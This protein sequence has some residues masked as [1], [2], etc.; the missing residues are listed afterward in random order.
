M[1]NEI[2]LQTR[3]EFLRRTV[4]GSS[5]TK[6]AIAAAGIGLI[7]LLVLGILAEAPVIGA[8]MPTSLGTIALD[9]MLGRDPGFVVGPILFNVVLVPILFGI[10]WLTF[11]RQEL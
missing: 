10:T 5:L 2:T 1:K 7:A 6:S 9:L 3:R 4:L 11:R 8:Y